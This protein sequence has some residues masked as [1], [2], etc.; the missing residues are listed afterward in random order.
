VAGRY[1]CRHPEDHLT[2][3]P[4]IL[5]IEDDDGIRDSIADCLADAYEV[6]TVV[7]G[8]DALEWLV[9][10]PRPAGILLDLVMPVMSGDEFLD[11][12][13]ATASLRDIPVLLMTAAIPGRSTAARC[14]DA[15]LTKPF[16][17]D[18]LLTAVRRLAAGER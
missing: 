6:S 7:N 10:E 12:L 5:V 16:E 17:L 9:R 4:R 18:E 11:R 8:A 3:R 1:N 15:L 14:A 2:E 13:R